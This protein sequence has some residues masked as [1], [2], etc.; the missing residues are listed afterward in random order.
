MTHDREQLLQKEADAWSA[1]LTAAE[2]VPA[3]L[4]TVPDVVP[5]WSVADLVFH[6]GKWAEVSGTH[7]EQMAAGTFVD[8]E[9]PD[10][11]WQAKNDAWAEESKSLSW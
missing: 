1:L 3:E 4:R 11:V 9:E 5:G 8:E 10:E 7:L 6:S 2:R